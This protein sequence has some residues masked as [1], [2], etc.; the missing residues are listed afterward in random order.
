[1]GIRRIIARFRRTPPVPVVRRTSFS[2]AW[3]LAMIAALAIGLAGERWTPTF[4]GWMAI[5]AFVMLILFTLR[6]PRTGIGRSL[7]WGVNLTFASA[8]V[9]AVATEMR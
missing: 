9:A 3:L 2:M 8:I 6:K 1:M 5:V 4:V 7:W